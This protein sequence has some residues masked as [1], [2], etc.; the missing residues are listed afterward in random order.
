[1]GSGFS[2]N[3]LAVFLVILLI[4]SSPALSL[5]ETQCD[6]IPPS[7]GAP[8]QELIDLCGNP[9]PITDFVGT[10]T[11]GD[12]AF[13]WEFVQSDLDSFEL[14]VPEV[15]IPLG[16]NENGP[17]TFITGCDFDN[18]GTFQEIYCISQEGVFYSLDIVTRITTTVGVATPFN[19]E[20]FTGLA[21]DPT[22]GIMYASSNDLSASSI[23]RVDLITGIATRVGTVTNSPGLIAIAVNNQGQMFGYDILFDSLIKIDKN[24][25]AGTVVGSLGFDA[26]FAQG[27]DFNKSDNKCYLFAFNNITFQA[28]LRT[29]NTKTGLTQFVGVLGATDPGGI[30]EVTGAGIATKRPDI[31][32]LPITPGVSNSANQIMAEGA[33]ANGNVA[34]VWGNVAGSVIVGGN[35]CNGLEINIK[36]FRLLGIARASFDQIANL[37]IFVPFFTEPQ[38]QVLTQAVDLKSCVKSEVI[39]NTLTSNIINN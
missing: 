25:G 23:Y 35:V 22:S 39:S 18:S 7:I 13:G 28:E 9:E 33:S 20:G 2:S 36:R 24:T 11:T 21:T 31:S 10:N 19:S 14:S 4:I 30:R 17:N 12:I 15:L 16:G 3:H 8:S 32:I 27:M 1:M 26:N 29:C 6:N 38:I 34:F 5:A 37:P